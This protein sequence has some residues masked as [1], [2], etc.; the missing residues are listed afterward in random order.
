M[1]GI[2]I[3]HFIL[4]DPLSRFPAIAGQAPHGGKAFLSTPS[5]VVKSRVYGREG[6]K[7]K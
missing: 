6:G 2:K 4:N 1:P 3:F 7:N 5:L